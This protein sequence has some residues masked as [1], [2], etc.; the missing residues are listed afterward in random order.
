MWLAY[1]VCMHWATA[2]LALNATAV[3]VAG[4]ESYQRMHPYLY[5]YYDDNESLAPSEVEQA[6]RNNEFSPP[7]QS[8]TSLGI[9]NESLWMR[10]ELRNS[11]AADREVVIEYV[12]HGVANLEL[13]QVYDGELASLGRVSYFKPFSERPVEHLRYAYRLSLPP[14]TTQTYYALFEV[15]Q[16][17]PLFADFRLWDEGAFQKFRSSELYFYGF[18]TGFLCLV[19]IISLV[20][21]LSTK[22]V[23]MIYYTVFVAANLYGWG[24]IY[25]FLPEVFFRDGHHW[26][27]MIIGGVVAVSSAAM[28]TR[29]LLELKKYTPRLDKL[30]LALVL[31]GALPFFG[32]LLGDTRIALIGM[33]IHLSGMLLLVTAALV[34]ALQGER[35]AIMFFVAW[36]LYL[37]GMLIYPARE[38]GLIEHTAFTYWV[39]PVGSILEVGL[40]LISIFILFRRLEHD[41]EQAQVLYTRGLEEQKERLSELVRERTRE[42][43]T[44]AERAELEARTDSLTQLP[45]RRLFIEQLT[46]EF[47]AMERSRAPLSLMLLDIDKFKQINDQY[48]HECGDFVLQS[49]AKALDAH[50][51]K[52]DLCARIGGEEFALMMPNTSVADAR[53]LCER[54]RKEVTGLVIRFEQMEIGVSF[55]GGLIQAQPGDTTSDLLK[56][57]DDLLYEGKRSGRN[58]IVTDASAA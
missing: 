35:L 34:R 21:Y 39:T 17:G 16:A 50:T 4:L 9:K 33:E 13:F 25:G 47:S 12:D 53:V 29:S 22:R 38:L 23:A 44:V 43:E 15:D 32:A 54:I 26:R 56:R 55:T 28:F 14:G 11:A 24:F 45:N 5:I 36:S 57:A 27:H 49:L 40:L 10:F 31:F 46:R 6:W 30:V 19:I 51:R 41:R 1:C 37:L 20:F 52:Q 42:L 8:G 48:G 2:C 18:L 7:L 58:R 3:D